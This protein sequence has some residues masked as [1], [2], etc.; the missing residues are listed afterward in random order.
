MNGL[1]DVGLR[2]HG[3]E[4]A[5]SKRRWNAG[6]EKSAI[7]IAHISVRSRKLHQFKLGFNLKHFL[8]GAFKDCGIF[9][10]TSK[11]LERVNLCLKDQELLKYQEA[12]ETRLIYVVPGE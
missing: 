7:R 2:S 3:V 9:W 1:R 4:F 5:P 12:L 11:T 8:M 10:Q 6:K